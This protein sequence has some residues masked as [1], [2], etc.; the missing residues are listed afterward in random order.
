MAEGE[1]MDILDTIESTPEDN[2]PTL[3]VNK[4][5]AI[6]EH[7]N[8]EI[9]DIIK[10]KS[11][12]ML[13]ELRSLVFT[14][15]TT[16]LP[17][18]VS[19]KMYARKK[20]ELIAEDIYVFAY[21]AVNALAHKKLNKCLKQ[22]TDLDSTN[23]SEID[24]D[25][26]DTHDIQSLVELCIK[27]EDRLNTLE[28]E[29][30]EQQEKI[31]ELEIQVCTLKMHSLIAQRDNVL[32]DGSRDQAEGGVSEQESNTNSGTRFAPPQPEDDPPVSPPT[33]HEAIQDE[34]VPEESHTDA[35]RR[36]S[37]LLPRSQGA[38]F[39][40]AESSTQKSS[41]SLQEDPNPIAAAGF[42]HSAHERK[43]ILKG[44]GH[45]RAI[46]NQR[47]IRGSSDTASLQH[48]HNHLVLH[49][50]CILVILN[51]PHLN[52]ISVNICLIKKLEIYQT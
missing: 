9:L 47:D 16:V 6:L 33:Y 27:L 52:L 36:H 8:E 39:H 11:K 48:N 18:Y 10:T 21:S 35:A 42:R 43:T 44:H 22:Q 2:I 19:R 25:N 15:F 7:S 51:P 23:V 4:L 30:K 37:I 17:Q 28:T 14:E 31:L 40:Q 5:V 13:I 12:K 41:S 32:L 49:S 1:N 26:Q 29:K 38:T 20:S 3:F 24:N 34:D 50:W 45:R 46:V